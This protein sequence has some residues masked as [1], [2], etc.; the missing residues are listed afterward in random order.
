MD[1]LRRTLA[2]TATRTVALLEQSRKLVGVARSEVKLAELRVKNEK[3]RRESGRST[4]FV[5][6]QMENTV[7][8]ARY[9]LLSARIAFLK[10]CADLAALTGTL[11]GDL[12]VKARAARVTVRTR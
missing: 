9:K 4:L 2:T 7:V 5:V 12:G 8:S 3:Q 6:H 10:G 11:L 1:D